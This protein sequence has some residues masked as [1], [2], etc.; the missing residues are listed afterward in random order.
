[1]QLQHINE[2]IISLARKQWEQS[3]MP[4]T[5]K[6]ALLEQYHKDEHAEQDGTEATPDQFFLWY[7]FNH[8]EHKTIDL[9]LS[10]TAINGS[11]TLSK[12]RLIHIGEVLERERIGQDDTVTLVTRIVNGTDTIVDIYLNDKPE[13]WYTQ[14][15]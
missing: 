4:G 5:M 1:M 11:I 6:N 14:D 2:Q 7:Y 10:G 13:V 12:T 9:I 3:D 8:I 15:Y